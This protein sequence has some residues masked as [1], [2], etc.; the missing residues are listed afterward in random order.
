V[1]ESVDAT[2]GIGRRL[3]D[4]G[5]IPSTPVR[6]LRRA[7]LGDPASYELRGTRIC[8]RASEALRILVRPAAAADSEL[9]VN[10]ADKSRA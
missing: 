8:L 4:L 7:P 5:F 1:I 9:A 2:S 10:S 3:L 6:T